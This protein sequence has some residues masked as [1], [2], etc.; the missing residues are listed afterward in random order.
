M[1]ALSIRQPWVYAI[2]HLPQDVRK[3]IENRDWQPENPGLKFRGRVLVHVGKAMTKA[4][5]Y[6]GLECIKAVVGSSVLRTFPGLK[7]LPRGG[8]AGA[9]TITGI[10]PPCPKCCDGGT[11]G[12]DHG[13]HSPNRYGLALL[14]AKPLP[15][16]I[17][18]NG[19]LGFYRVGVDVERLVRAM[20][21]TW[22]GSLPG[23]PV[24]NV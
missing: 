6:D 5:Y 2:L 15:Q 14:D 8:V 20:A 3:D 11:C 16:L 10:L 18:C 12:K 23:H 17:P 21:R 24:E 9:V 19:Q 13:W 4:E 22:H 1:M 7:D